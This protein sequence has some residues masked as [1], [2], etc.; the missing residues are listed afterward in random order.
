M[1]RKHVIRIV[2]LLM[3][4]LLLILAWQEFTSMGVS[5]DAFV[6]GTGGVMLCLMSALGWG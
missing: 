6:P 3:G 4:V 2:Y 5:L 1:T